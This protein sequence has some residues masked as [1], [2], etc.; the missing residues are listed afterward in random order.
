MKICK[1]CLESD[2]LCS[3]CNRKLENG[4][5]KKVEV[6]LSRVLYKFGKEKGFVIDFVSA[7][8]NDGKVF[9]VVESEHAAKFIG[10][11]GR[12]IKKFST[13]LG[14]QIKLLEKAE[15]NERHVIERMIG[16]PVLGI[17]K[18]YSGAESYKIRVE[19][20]YTRAVQPLSNVVGK[21]LNK[22]VSFIFE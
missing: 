18:I 12:N 15:G 14:R 20:R 3:A 19:K 16:V 4:N 8:E 22:K 10:P 7:L 21:V 5:I 11:G 6:D 1:V 13:M 2:M 17:N 9:V